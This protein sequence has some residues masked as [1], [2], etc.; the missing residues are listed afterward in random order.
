VG[1][2][3]VILTDRCKSTNLEIPDVNASFMYDIHVVICDNITYGMS[4][5]DCLAVSNF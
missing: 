1:T 5:R 2:P 4:I 3:K